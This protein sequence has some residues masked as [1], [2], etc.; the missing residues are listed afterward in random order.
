MFASLLEENCTAEDGIRIEPASNGK[1][2]LCFL[3]SNVII[4]IRNDIILIIIIIMTITKNF[5]R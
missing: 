4:I 1:N 2:S 3:P 5:T